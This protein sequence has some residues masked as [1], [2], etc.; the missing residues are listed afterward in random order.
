MELAAC[1]I[2]ARGLSGL[3][4]LSIAGLGL[5]TVRRRELTRTL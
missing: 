3:A 2:M 4:R 1:N 5:D